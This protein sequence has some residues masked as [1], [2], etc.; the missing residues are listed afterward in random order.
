MSPSR[1]T[2]ADPGARAPVSA[3]GVDV[4]FPCRLTTVRVPPRARWPFVRLCTSVCAHPLPA[5]PLVVVPLL[6]SKNTL[7]V[8]DTS[9]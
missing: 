2:D 8:V 6:S 1:M 9:V 5:S 3:S 7:C 4:W